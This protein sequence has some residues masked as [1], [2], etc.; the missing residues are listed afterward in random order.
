MS[1]GR[2]TRNNTLAAVGMSA[3]AANHP[4]LA[5]IPATSGMPAT[6]V[7]QLQQGYQ[8]LAVGYTPAKAKDASHNSRD[9][10][11]WRRGTNSAAIGVQQQQ[12]GRQQGSQMQ[13]QFTSNSK[14]ACSSRDT[15]SSRD[16]IYSDTN[17]SATRSQECHQEHHCR[18]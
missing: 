14:D 1:N 17:L 15:S 3:T 4:E 8:Q 13:S 5:R 6:E 12:M 11:S 16:I 2:D 9:A 7:S 10:S 18:N